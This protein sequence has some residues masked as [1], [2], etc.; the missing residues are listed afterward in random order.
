MPDYSLVNREIENHDNLIIQDQERCFQFVK[1]AD[2][3][4][5]LKHIAGLIGSCR[6]Q[7]QGHR[8]TIQ[9]PDLL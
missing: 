6:R 9:L 1:I 4:L 7:P 8:R 2:D 5:Y 3:S